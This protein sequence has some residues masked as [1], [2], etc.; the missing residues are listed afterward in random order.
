VY[1]YEYA[2]RI[3][4]RQ[5]EII[6]NLYSADINLYQSVYQPGQMRK[7][8]RYPHRFLYVGRLEPIKGLDILLSAW[9]KLGNERRGWELHLIGNGSL[10][11]LVASENGVVLRDFM[12]PNQLIHQ[13]RD[14]GCFVLPS[15][16]E[17]WGVVV[18][19]FAA[20]GLPLLVSDVVGAASAFLLPGWNGFRFKANNPAALASAMERIIGTPDSSL[21]AMG[22]ASHQLSHRITPE[23]SAAS[24]L[25]LV[26]GS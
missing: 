10:K 17:P 25:S 4:F 9:R 22:C 20:A 14:A 19:E 2:R 12:D 11:K 13:A 1:Q 15:K 3:G 23:I 18:H 16:T 8:E 6:G 21:L 5:D 24:L 7:S 26:D